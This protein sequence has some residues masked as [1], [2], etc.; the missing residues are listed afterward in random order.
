MGQAGAVCPSSVGQSLVCKGA[1]DAGLPVCE[2]INSEHNVEHVDEPFSPSAPSSKSFDRLDISS[3]QIIKAICML[4]GPTGSHAHELALIKLAAAA[5]SRNG[6]KTL[7]E[8]GGIRAILAAMK[9]S[10]L[11]EDSQLAACNALLGMCL[12]ARICQEVVAKGGVDVMLQFLR[13]HLSSESVVAAAC[14]VLQK[15]ALA[16]KPRGKICS[17]GGLVLIERVMR[18]HLASAEVQENGCFVLCNLALDTKTTA[19]DH[20]SNVKIVINAMQWHPQNISVLGAAICTLYNLMCKGDFADVAVK[21]GGQD[22]LKTAMSKHG[23]LARMREAQALSAAWDDIEGESPKMLKEPAP[24]TPRKTSAAGKSQSLPSTPEGLASHKVSLFRGIKDN[25][26]KA[27]NTLQ[28][29]RSSAKEFMQACTE[30]SK[31]S[32]SMSGKWRIIEVGAVPALVRGMTRPDITTEMLLAACTAVWDFCNSEETS[33]GET[34]CHEVAN[35]G[36][37]EVTIR[38]LSTHRNS[39]HVA[40]AA[41]K[42]LQQLALADQPRSEICSQ[43]GLAAIE[44]AMG[45]HLASPGVQESGC[46]AICNLA[47]QPGMLLYRKNVGTI[48]ASMKGHKENVDVQEAAVCALYNLVCTGNLLEAVIEMGGG[49]VVGSAMGI[50]SRIAQMAEAKAISEAA[51]EDGLGLGLPLW[52]PTPSTF[53]SRNIL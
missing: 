50:H 4:K 28:N 38:A 22:A 47:L 51:D 20:H 3:D 7:A 39:V 30:L 46:S 16:S 43:G 9:H 42:V 23:S 10:G 1:V 8:A 5:N 37:V 45:Q 32:S 34:F 26:T 41:C 36:G 21:C 52:G 18:R 11:T 53:S 6:S 31:S 24:D 29:P 33:Q 15:L 17:Q 48:I 27:A 35:K 12:E 49:S 44:Q 13:C 19:K 2:A 14:K 25:V 40:E